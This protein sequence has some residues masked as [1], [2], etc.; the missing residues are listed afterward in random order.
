MRNTKL[1]ISGIIKFLAGLVLVILLI[2]LPT[3]D[4][5]Y[6]NGWIL[7]A[8]LF[9]PMLVAGIIMWLKKPELLSRRLNAKEKQDGQRTVIAVSAVM[10][11]SGF[12]I[13]GL[14]VK[15]D[16]LVLPLWMSL[17]FTAVFI[18]GYI[19]Y[20]IVISQN[21]YLSRTIEV[22]DS[23]KVIDTGI[24]SVVR[25]P[26][27]LATILMFMSMPLILGS[28]MGFLVFLAYPFII[29][30]RIKKEEEFLSE[31]LSGY[32]DY[33]KKVKYRMIPKIW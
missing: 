1:L 12:V 13:S 31:N 33:I 29:A 30:Y 20:G 7:T 22:S 6:I 26:M 28:V 8:I 27:Y 25:H 32:S 3:G 18:A 23:Q 4:L 5:G 17:I 14:C 16:F 15:Y 9:V 2:F 10:F 19:L 24:Y 21:E 11:I